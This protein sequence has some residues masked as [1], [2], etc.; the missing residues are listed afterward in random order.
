[1]E[2]MTTLRELLE[3]EQWKNESGTTDLYTQY[4]RQFTESELDAP[5]PKPLILRNTKVKV[6]SPKRVSIL[7][8]VRESFAAGVNEITSPTSGKKHFSSPDWQATSPAKSKHP[9]TPITPRARFALDESDESPIDT[10]SPLKHKRSIFG[11][12]KHPLKSPFP[13]SNFIDTSESDDAET[14]SPKAKP[15]GKRFSK[16]LSG[17]IKRAT[18]T[19][20]PPIKKMSTIKN[21]ERDATGPDTPLPTKPGFNMQEVYTNARK[22]LSIKTAEEK[23]RDS[24]RRKIVVVG[25]TDQGPGMSAQIPRD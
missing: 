1:M 22:T 12:G 18:S 21:G 24:L 8:N 7:S 5:V 17:A 16:R 20:M 9:N 10:V 14:A 13:F 3:E 15:Q 6:K 2:D 25:L 11:T 19:H 4:H 23:K